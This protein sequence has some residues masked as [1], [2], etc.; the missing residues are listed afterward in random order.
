MKLHT[1]QVVTGDQLNPHI[2]SGHLSGNR[3][4]MYRL[5][6]KCHFFYALIRR[7]EPGSNNHTEHSPK[8]LVLHIFLSRK[9]SSM[10]RLESKLNKNRQVFKNNDNLILKRLESFQSSNRFV[11]TDA[12]YEISDLGVGVTNERV[13][14]S[15]GARSEN[16]R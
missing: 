4:R 11:I 2:S 3:V 1:Q 13:I 7:K 15:R 5:A 8:Y 9:V 10:I 16:K 12:V 14:T 6:R